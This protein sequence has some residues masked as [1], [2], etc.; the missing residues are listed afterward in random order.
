MS[1]EQRWWPGRSPDA[2][3]QGPAGD[4]WQVAS[5]SPV[6]ERPRVRRGRRPWPAGVRLLAAAVAGA[7]VGA[8]AVTLGVPAYR[9]VAQSTPLI[10]TVPV[11][12]AEESVDAPAVQVY[13]E[14]SPSVV[15]VTNQSSIPSYYGPEQQV[16]WG[17]GVV[18][19]PNGYIV[20][21]AHVVVG[22]QQVTVTLWNG[23]SYPARLVGADTSTDLAVIK[24][25]PRQP[26]KPAVFADSNDVVPGE[27][28]IAIGN[29]LGPEFAESVT[30]GVV[31]AIR[32]MLYGG[33]STGTVP[34]RVTE[35]IQTDAPINPGNSGGARANAQGEVIGITSMKVAQTGEPGVAATG[36]G[37]AIPSNTVKTIVND[38]MRYG[39][40]PRA[41]LGVGLDV[42]PQNA[43]PTQPQTLTVAEVDQGGPAAQAGL[44]VGDVLTTW[45]GKPITNYWQ[46]VG[47][48]NAASPGQKVA[49]GVDRQGRSL[50]LT[51][52]LGTLPASLENG[53]ASP[54]TVPSAPPYPSPFPFPFPFPFP[55]FGPGGQ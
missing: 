33:D 46:L 13:K 1:S 41:W 22:A 27:L 48:I 24:I 12:P 15:L 55:G 42:S 38:L 51:V 36:L 2:G 16:D 6:P 21:N 14:L 28:A 19:T 40:V 25:S 45:N 50:T 4:W 43:L 20:T 47:D 17:S 39:Y 23:Q 53:T 11:T 35:M 10:T 30:V 54:Q 29:P 49:L 5:G 52:T 32:P 7:V 9:A 26:L 44:Q 31:S 18:L 34:P 8:A 3:G 37:F